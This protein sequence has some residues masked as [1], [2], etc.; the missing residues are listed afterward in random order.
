MRKQITNKVLMI[1][2]AG[3]C[4]NLQT[5]PSNKFQNT[6]ADVPL[7][8]IGE[9]AR[10]E[11]KT[12]V[13]K[14]EDAG[15]NVSIYEGQQDCPD[16]VFP[17]N[18]ISTHQEGSVVLYPMLTEN[19]RAERRVDIINE[20]SNGCDEVWDISDKENQNLILEGT[21]SLV[22]DR[23]NKVAYC[24]LS[25]RSNEG[26]AEDWAER[27]GYELVSFPTQDLDGAS[28][29]HTNVMMFIASNMAGICLECIPDEKIRDNVRA[30]LSKHHKMLEL[31]MKQVYS[32]CGNMLELESIDKEKTLVMSENAYDALSENQLSEINQNTDS[33]VVASIPTIEA[34]GGGSVR[35]MLLELF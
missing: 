33:L 1:K 15:I 2:P 32:F 30:K 31:S 24:A 27:M 5:A 22:L 28:I 23:V 35:C 11:M 12:F 20:L 16:D 6:Q 14:L 3:F 17:N 21:G 8:E 19:R 25:E 29:Y 9:L 4:S 10:K 13:S 18:W 7:S 34:Y 26:V